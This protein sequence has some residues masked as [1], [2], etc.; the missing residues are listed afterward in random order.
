MLPPKLV[1]ALKRAATERHQDLSAAVEEWIGRGL[2]EH[3]ARK[4][5]DATPANK[6]L[7][8]TKASLV[9]LER[10]ERAILVLRGHRVIL[11]SDLAALYGVPVKRLNEQVK[12]TPA[13]SRPTSLSV[14]L[15]EE[16]D[17]LKV[18]NCDLRS[19]APASTG[20]SFPAPLPST[21]RSWPPRC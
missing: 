21:A 19:G 12:R 4:S 1:K 11:D 8:M 17:N 9:P 5:A 10:V 3:E 15:G 16:C 2:A 20:N 14:S 18:A 13:D 6:K 7:A